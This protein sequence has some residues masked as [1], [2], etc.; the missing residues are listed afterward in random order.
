MAKLKLLPI[1][2][3]ALLSCCSPK[4]QNKPLESPMPASS[5]AE[6]KSPLEEI[7]NSVYCIRTKFKYGE[8][9]FNIS[10]TLLCY[11][12]E[13]GYYYLL[14][15]YHNL[16]PENFLKTIKVWDD[17][18]KLKT[19]EYAIVDNLEDNEKKDDIPL[20]IVL[21]DKSNDIAILKTNKK[22]NVYPYDIGD[23]SDVKPGD[24]V[25]SIGYFNGHIKFTLTATVASLESYSKEEFPN[26]FEIAMPGMYP[27]LSGSLVIAQKE[28][29]YK[30]VGVVHEYIPYN[31]ITLCIKIN[32]IKNELQL[33]K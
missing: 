16:N 21:T 24:Q 11:K 31:D 4:I 10:G 23:I 30:F 5:V 15:N 7:A 25:Y 14:T 28:G 20:E 26:D 18:K 1:T 17:K 19:E 9:E 3:A 6:Q 29:I 27:G 12:E 8:E 33:A 32:A 13:N 22:L 2:L